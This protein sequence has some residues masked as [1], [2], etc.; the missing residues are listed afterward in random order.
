MAKQ[1]P[2]GKLA[3]RTSMKGGETT[4]SITRRQIKNPDGSITVEAGFDLEEAPIPS[5]RY[6]ADTAAVLR[7]G[8]EVR[9]LFGQ[10]KVV[11]EG[12][13]SLISIAMSP[14]AVRRFLES[15]R[16]FYP[17]LADFMARNGLPD[18]PLCEI[19]EEPTQTVQLVANLAAVSH[20]GREV[21]ADFYYVS[22]W[23]VRALPRNH[24]MAIDPIVRIDTSVGVIMAVLHALFAMEHDLPGEAR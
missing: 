17:R 1:E 4:V 13:R 14:E 20:A 16:D 21:C 2:K 11:G 7:R 10:T 12:L 3:K 9:I 5:R 24:D 15:C 6:H 18:V 23:A 19:R 22:P 8:D